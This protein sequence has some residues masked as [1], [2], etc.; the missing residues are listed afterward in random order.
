MDIGI[1]I[2]NTVLD[3][4]GP[5][6]V[7]WAR[8]AEERGFSTLASIGRIAY[9]SNDELIAFGAGAAVTERIGLMT[10]ILLAPAF[11]TAILAKQTATLDRISGGRFVLGAGVGARPDDFAVA[12]AS[13]HDRGSRFDEQ[14]EALHRAW[15]GEPIAGTDKP[16]APPATKGAVRMAFAGQPLKAAPRLSAGTATTR[17]EARPPS[18]RL[19]RRRSSGRRTPTLVARGTRASSRCST[20]P[21][22]RN[23]RR[24]PF[25]TC[26]ATTGTSRNGWRASPRARPAAPTTSS[27]A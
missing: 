1:G 18:R 11:P 2:P 27:R 7:D 8:R 16:V 23:T 3:T 17:S 14:L 10:N 12:G 22:A 21:S 20:S 25:A 15:R 26:G 9:P 13:F 24:S 5:L 6:F 4:P 19:S